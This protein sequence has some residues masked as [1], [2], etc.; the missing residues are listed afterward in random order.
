MLKLNYLNKLNEEFELLKSLFKHPRLY[1]R[2]YFQR[3]KNEL[4]DLSMSESETKLYA[5][6]ISSFEAECLQLN[7]PTDNYNSCQTNDKIKYIKMILNDLNENE[8]LANKMHE[9][10]QHEIFKLEK[11]IFNNKTIFFKA[12]KLIIVNNMY[13][14][15]Q[16]VELFKS[17]K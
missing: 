10:I 14:G 8:L 13:L 15:R 3:L 7:N 2:M 9:I 17:E 1:L 16:L 5:E 4:E 6:R 12:K 11:L